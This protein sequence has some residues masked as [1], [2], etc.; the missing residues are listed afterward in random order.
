MSVIMETHVDGGA[1]NSCNFAAF[2][3]CSLFIVDPLSSE[4]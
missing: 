3:R 2:K 4:P 1:L